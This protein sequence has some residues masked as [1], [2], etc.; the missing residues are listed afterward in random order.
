MA[1]IGHTKSLTMGDAAGTV[2]FWNGATTSSVAAT[3]IVRPGDWNSAHGFTQTI[4]GAA[5]NTYG[6]STAA[7]TNLVFGF[8]GELYGSMSTGA[9]AATL[10]VGENESPLFT[11]EPYPLYMMGTAGSSTVA[12]GAATRGTMSIFPFRARRAVAAGYLQMNMLASFTTVGTS[13]GRQ[14]AGMCYGLYSLGSGT[15]SGTLYTFESGSFSW[16]VTA[17]NSSYTIAQ[18]TS[19]DSAGYTYGNTNSAGVNITSGYTGYKMVHLPV[20]MTLPENEY[21]LGI[22]GT[23]STSSINA[24]M[25]LYMIGAAQNTFTN[26]APIGSYSS[27]FS[28]GV[29]LRDHWGGPWHFAHGSHTLAN[30]T[31]CPATVA[32]TNITA[33]NPIMPHMKFWSR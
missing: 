23:N 6:T 14:T 33:G 11:Y 26:L 17:N 8:T 2:T 13:S 1:A 32:I 5:G 30:L 24:G 29:P 3:D 19:T 28:T 4:S 10:W 12:L 7:G 16:G 27:A 25:S 9:G 20:G 21:W 31:S 18:P 22:I 15:D